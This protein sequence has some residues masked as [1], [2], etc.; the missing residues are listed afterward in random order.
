M[1]YSSDIAFSVACPIEFGQQVES[2]LYKEQNEYVGKLISGF[3][4]QCR[5]GLAIYDNFDLKVVVKDYYDNVIGTYNGYRARLSIGEYLY[6]MVNVQIP[7]E[8]KAI[9]FEVYNGSELLATSLMYN[10]N[11]NYKD[12]LKTIYYTKTYNDFDT[13]F[14][15][16][17]NILVF[18]TP[19]DAILKYFYVQITTKG[20]KITVV[21]RDALN[22]AYY[23]KIYNKDTAELL[24]TTPTFV[25]FIINSGYI[26]L[27]T[28]TYIEL[29]NNAGVLI[30]SSQGRVVYYNG[31][32][33]TNKLTFALTVECI[34]NPSTLH[35]KSK[36]NNF[37][38]QF[39]VNKPVASSP[40]WTIDLNIGTG[41]GIPNWMAIKLNCIFS[42]NNLTID[43][44]PVVRAND[45]T[46]ELLEMTYDGIGYYKQE[47]QIMQS[48][49]QNIYSEWR[50][51]NINFNPNF[52]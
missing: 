51:F 42:C 1:I 50:V 47:L 34:L 21:N 22:H 39:Y 19:E 24:I 5:I 40:Y 29:Y 52:S 36:T 38:N 14:N 15:E 12:D 41:L 11:P 7:S 26:P 2:Y 44:M 46:M 48:F 30:G 25:G 23:A 16:D 43:E 13:I 3:T 35:I 45:A 8:D 28:P 33:Y 18:D 4:L 17:S 9:Y 20:H 31:T 27:N 32:S 37:F 10:A 49:L 6:A